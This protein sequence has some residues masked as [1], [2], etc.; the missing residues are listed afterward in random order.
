MSN[1]RDDAQGR[2]EDQEQPYGQR[3]E[4]HDSSAHGQPDAHGEPSPYGQTEQYGDVGYGQA[5]YGQA[6]YGRTEPFGQP[7]YGQP[8]PYGQPGYGQPGYGQPGYGQP[9]PYGQPGYGQYGG[10]GQTAAPARPGGVITAAV[11]GFVLGAL[12]V[13]VSFFLVVFGAAVAG[14]AS[15]LQDVP[16][17][18]VF[19]GAFAGVLLVL[20]LLAAVWTVLMIWGSAWALTGR[21]RVMLIVGGSIAILATGVTLIGSLSDGDRGGIVFALLLFAAAVATVVLLCLPPAIEFFAAS[22]AR[23]GR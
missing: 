16:G 13:V 1:E 21:T 12:G 9:Q 2:S 23:R 17:L 5:G 8:Q 10:Y 3:P 4:A 14:G 11:L 18:D 7:G 19:S 22:R 6:G 15:S 20:G